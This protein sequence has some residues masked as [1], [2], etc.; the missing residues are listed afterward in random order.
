[1]LSALAAF[2][3]LIATLTVV[4]NN[5]YMATTMESA[6]QTLRQIEAERE[7]VTWQKIFLNNL[8][9]SLPLV[10]PAIG[11]IPFLFAW[12]NTGA[13]IG[14]LAKA[15]GIQPATYVLTVATLAFPEILAYTLLT[16]E[17]IYLSA[18]TL[19]GAGAKARLGHSWKT[20]I[21]YMLLLFIGA[22]SEALMLGS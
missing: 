21:F 19:T 14:M 15:T 5:V 17:N 2:F 1:M 11:L 18:L 9:I 13:T 22:V 20:I 6:N 8:F 7:T 10:I 16:A 3:L 4:A 12:V